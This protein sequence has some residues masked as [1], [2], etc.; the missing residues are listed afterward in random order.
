[1]RALDLESLE[2]TPVLEDFDPTAFGFYGPGA[3]LLEARGRLWYY[4][5][6][7]EGVPALVETPVDFEFL[8]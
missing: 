8:R 6:T 2:V 4:D 1:M 5:R 7:R 3:L